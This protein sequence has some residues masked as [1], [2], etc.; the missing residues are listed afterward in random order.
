MQLDE[1]AAVAALR[2]E[3]QHVSAAG[4]TRTGTR[5]ATIENVSPFGAVSRRRLVLAADDDRAARACLG[6]IRWF[7][8]DAPRQLRD[9]WDVSAVLLT[10]AN[11]AAAA[12]RLTFPPADGFFNHPDQPESRYVWRWATYQAPDVLVE[13]RGGD[14]LSRGTPPD[15]SLAAAMAGGSEMGT[16][17]SMFV[18]ARETDGPAFFK[19]VLKDVT[20]NESEVHATLRSRAGRAPLAI[21]QVLADK[22]PQTPAVSYIPSVSWANTLRLSDAIKSDALRQKVLEQ[23]RPWVSR[24]RPLFAA[25]PALTA[26]AGTL[27]YADLA[28]RGEAAAEPLAVQGADE[29]LKVAATGYAE[30]GQGWTDDMF[31]LASIL[32]RSGRM[33]GRAGD[34]DHLARMLVSYAERLQR[35]DGVFVHFTDGRIPWG[36]GNGF[37]ALGLTE[38][39][40]TLSTG[41][42]S[43]PSRAAVL[44]IYRRQMNGMMLMQAPD[45]MW[46]QVV[47]EP[48]AYR[49]ESVTAMT[50]TAMVRGVRLRWL[51]AGVY[52]PVIDRAW[53]ALAAHITSDGAIVDICTSTGSQPTLQQY[54][55]R[56]AISGFDDRGG[57]MGLLASMEMYDLSRAG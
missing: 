31:M 7:K 44:Q 3:P 1:V 14:V 35:P 13:V 28:L 39:L 43:H 6:A 5:L 20:G 50:L 38:A 10:V 33:R 25:R 9:R 19:Y 41:P 23:T 24:E 30:Y 40:T 15:G 2:G 56:Q 45:G 22:Y 37:A 26:I 46:R 48:G 4:V 17:H 8:T 29:A 47:D 57:A 54:L 51:D 32:S 53:R 18:T 49:E 21:A 12:R 11:D 42:A 16:V 27:I 55:D 52:R 34:V 36:R